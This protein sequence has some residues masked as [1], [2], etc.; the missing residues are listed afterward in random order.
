MENKIDNSFT[1][2][3]NDKRIFE[4]FCDKLN[5][6]NLNLDKFSEK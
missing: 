3:N 6:R 1:D 5:E 2:R 4:E